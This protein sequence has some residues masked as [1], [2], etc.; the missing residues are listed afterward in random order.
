MKW[1]TTR[2]IIDFVLAGMLIFEMLYML[3]GNVLHEVVGVAFFAT[4][5]L[6]M[7]F[8]RRWFKAM[9]AKAASPNGL[10]GKQKVRLGLVA[11]L[12][13]LLGLLLVSSLLISN[14]LSSLTGWALADEP[15]TLW[16][17]AHTVGA[18]VFCAFVICHIGA[19]WVG[20]FKALRIPYS[21]ARRQ[22]IG[23]GVTSL[24]TVGVVAVTLS[25]AKTLGPWM[26]DAEGSGDMAATGE[27]APSAG[28]GMGDVAGQ[29]VLEEVPGQGGDAGRSTDPRSRRPGPE[30]RG[31]GY[32]DS[33]TAPD[34]S[35]RGTVPDA[36]SQNDP[37]GQSPYGN[38][39]RGNSGNGSGGDSYGY[40]SGDGSG[41]GGNSGNS[42]GICTLCRRRC[43]LSAPQCNKPYS[44]GL[45]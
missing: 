40:G 25:A 36:D 38:G 10:A 22:A 7:L 11:V 35:Q 13:A 24:A 3:T 2:S 21:P 4:L 45:L 19:H 5:A 41:S 6:H 26:P 33:R 43:S 32:G 18:Y 37:W 34:G 1:R 12:A 30:S 9:G 42:S 39:S 14:M 20:L 29:D 27:G 15:Y 31:Y 28:K 17:V 23:A 8:A 44:A 16:A